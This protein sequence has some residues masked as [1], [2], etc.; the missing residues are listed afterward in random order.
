MVNLGFIVEG[1][2]E[3]IIIESERFS[4]F[5]EQ[6][7]F[8]LVKPVI[9]ARGGGNLLPQNIGVFIQTLKKAG[10]EQICVLTDL[11]DEGSVDIVRERIS[12]AEVDQIFVAVKALEAWF[13]ADTGAM[14]QWLGEDGFIESYPENTPDKPWDRLKELVRLYSVRG[15]GSKVA[16][17]NKMVKHFNFD[18]THASAHEHCLSAKE[19]VDFFTHP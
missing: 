18:V 8:L 4:A 16:F 1:D 9:N 14:R 15:T 3:K 17:A 13:L 12:N 7:N 11:E 10:V 6:N 2:S 19:L 5:L